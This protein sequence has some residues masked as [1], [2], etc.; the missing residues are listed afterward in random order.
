MSSKIDPDQLFDPEVLRALRLRQ[1]LL[2]V[3]D[4]AQSAIIRID[5]ALVETKDRPDGAGFERRSKL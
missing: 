5:T 2:Q 1:V 3:R 4:I